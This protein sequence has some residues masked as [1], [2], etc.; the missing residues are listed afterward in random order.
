MDWMAS[1]EKCVFVY[2]FYILSAQGLQRDENTTE[3][4]ERSEK[5][6]CEWIQARPKV[7]DHTRTKSHATNANVLFFFLSL[8]LSVSCPNSKFKQKLTSI[9]RRSAF[10]VVSPT[11]TSQPPVV[12]PSKAKTKTKS[13]N[14]CTIDNVNASSPKSPLPPPPVHKPNRTPAK[15]KQSMPINGGQTQK[16]GRINGRLKKSNPSNELSSKLLKLKQCQEQILL[17]EKEDYRLAQ[18]LQNYE[19]NQH[20]SSLAALNSNG[21]TRYS[22]RSRGKMLNANNNLPRL[23]N[24]AAPSDTTTSDTS[25]IMSDAKLLKSL[26]AN[27]RAR[28]GKRATVEN[29]FDPLADDWM[30]EK[31]LP[32]RTR[33][34][35]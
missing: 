12:V 22:L 33:N 32:R 20:G 17:Q 15:G 14:G 13:T 16:N 9:H 4:I 1:N 30:E 8:S 23:V 3:E 6:C 31:I 24:S 35:Q 21:S 25:S 27:T 10:Y 18:I 2:F 11:P 5:K 19:N 26:Q 34:R 7:S 28:R 29:Y